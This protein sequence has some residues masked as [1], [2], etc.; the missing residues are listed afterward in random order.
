MLCL[1]VRPF[2]ISMKDCQISVAGYCFT[3]YKDLPFREFLL[4]Q[5]EIEAPVLTLKDIVDNKAVIPDVSH[6]LPLFREY[7]AK[8]YYPFSNEPGFEIRVN[9]MVQQTIESDI[10]Q[11]AD[12]KPAT[13]RK[14]K[15]LLSVVSSLAPYKP[16]FDNLSKEVGISK[17]NVPDYLT[18]LEKAEFVRVASRQYVRHAFPWQD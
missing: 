1:Q 3:I 4:I 10:S 7:L 17:N 18:Y 2:S 14:L 11:Y 5:H 9:Q 16:N 13:A 15:Q 12:L 6:P 8:G